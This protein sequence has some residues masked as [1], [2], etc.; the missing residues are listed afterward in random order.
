MKDELCE[1]K[2]IEQI[3]KG[4][5]QAFSTLISRH[6]LNLL[7]YISS[8][9]TNIEDAEDICQIA[10][11][12]AFSAINSFNPKY[13]F[14]TWLYNIAKNESIDFYRKKSQISNSTTNRKL[15]ELQDI[16]DPIGSPEDKFITDQSYDEVLEIINSLDEQYR[17]I[18]TLR[19]IK[20][21]EYSQIAIL[22][23]LPLN[24]VK[25]R[26]RRGRELLINNLKNRNY[27]Y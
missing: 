4:D 25:T 20:D 2:L 7:K 8:H 15:D 21:L 5:Q 12:K 9:T 10:F 26:I 22:V 11:R 17:E 6:E 13:A 19:F 23:R 3:I 1:E 27:E 24:T 18:C 14:S 16:I